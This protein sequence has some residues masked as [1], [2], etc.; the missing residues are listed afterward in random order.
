MADR[1]VGVAGSE[2]LV[3]AAMAIDA[4]GSGSGA[5]PGRAGMHGARVGLLSSFV[6]SGA[7][8]L[9][10]RRVVDQALDVGVA[11]DAAEQPSVERM[12]HLGL[13]DVETDLLA[14][15]V[16]AERRIPM[17]AKAV[18]VLDLRGGPPAGNS[19]CQQEQRSKA[20]G[21]LPGSVAAGVTVRG[22]RSEERRV[23]KEGRV[24]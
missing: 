16:A 22:W 1:R 12:L 11:I 19:K 8:D 13:V 2:R 6:A 24:R 7:G 17:A 3:R 15:F 5:G 9:L 10:G 18:G 14:V 21:E 20:K 4:G 23:G